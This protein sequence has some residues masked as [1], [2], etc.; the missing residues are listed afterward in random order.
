MTLSITHTLT[1]KKARNVSYQLRCFWTACTRR[2]EFAEPST[3][4]TL[5]RLHV[6]WYDLPFHPGILTRVHAWSGTCTSHGQALV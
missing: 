5:P 6:S 2:L 1:N 3:G 4:K